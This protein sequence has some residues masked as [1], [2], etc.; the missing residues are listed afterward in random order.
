M[1]I[2]H[3]HQAGLLLAL[4]GPLSGALAERLA[5]PPGLT[6]LGEAARLPN[7]YRGQ[8]AAI[9]AGQAA[10]EEHCAACHGEQASRAVAEGP[11][12]RRL[13][14][15]CR[16]LTDAALQAH[17]LRDVDAY[18]LRSVHE[19][20]RRA[21][22]MHMPAWQGVLP[23]ETIWAIRSFTESRPLPPPR[24]LPDLPPVEPDR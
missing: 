1:P 9:Q 15:A 19:G 8:P 14:S 10:Y 17:C 18:F 4:A 7:P 6:P 11:D 16:R 12:L 13:N 2:R 21:G 3:W 24:T 23:Q 20:K 22:L 5:P